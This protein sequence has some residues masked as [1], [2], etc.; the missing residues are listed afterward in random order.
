[1]DGVLSGLVRERATLALSRG[2]A[3]KTQSLFRFAA[4]LA[5]MSASVYACTTVDT[6]TD[7]GSA[8]PPGSGG[9]S[10]G[11][12]SKGMSGSDAQGGTAGSTGG[13]G[14][15]GTNPGFAGTITIGV[16]AMSDVK[17][18]LTEDAACG[19]GEAEANL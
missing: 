19:T 16:D 3:M 4:S 10:G 1:M 18:E 6:G 5:A 11:R 2:A 15:S 12:S 9:S 13:T 17:E 14:S 7:P 8:V